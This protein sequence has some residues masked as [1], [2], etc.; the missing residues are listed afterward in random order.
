[1]NKAEHD[2]QRK[3]ARR[4]DR[5][6]RAAWKRPHH[7]WRFWVAIALMLTGIAVYVLTDSEALRP[8]SPAHQPMPETLG[9]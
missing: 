2:A 6:R 1:M 9:N 7:D 5:S 3:S 8:G 4:E